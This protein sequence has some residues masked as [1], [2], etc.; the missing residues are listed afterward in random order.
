M[1]WSAVSA[2]F[3]APLALAGTL[4]ADLVPRTDGKEM[5]GDKGYGM[6]QTEV[7]VEEIVLVWSCNG[8][9][10]STKTMNHVSTMAGA[11]MATHTVRLCVIS[12]IVMLT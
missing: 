3:A 11:A 12:D 9:G 2:L 5:M 1:K 4:Q 6:G 7:V 8:G 10:E